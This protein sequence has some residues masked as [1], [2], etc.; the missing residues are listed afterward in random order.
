MLRQ[1][2]RAV[3]AK[4]VTYNVLHRLSSGSNLSG[5]TSSAEMRCTRAT[6]VKQVIDVDQ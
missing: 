4:A 1:C 3:A 2:S 6:R 5:D